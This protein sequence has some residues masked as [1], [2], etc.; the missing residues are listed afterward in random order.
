[1]NFLNVTY[2]II[3]PKPWLLGNLGFLRDEFLNYR[4]SD[5]VRGD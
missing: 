5:T 2:Y 3:L 4:I 1:M